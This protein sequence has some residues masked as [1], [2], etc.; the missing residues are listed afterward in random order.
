ML[1]LHI[2]LDAVDINIQKHIV[3]NHIQN[4]PLLKIIEFTSKINNSEKFQVVQSH[5][6]H[7]AAIDI[8]FDPIL[9]ELKNN[10]HKKIY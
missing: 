2:L 4:N 3:I 10:Q 9:N 7:S 5:S 8:L 1:K 6:S